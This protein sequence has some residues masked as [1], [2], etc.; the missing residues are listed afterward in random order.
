MGKAMLSWRE[1]VEYQLHVLDLAEKVVWQQ[2]YY[3]KI[4]RNVLQI[5]KSHGKSTKRGMLMYM[6]K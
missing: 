4:N 2:M 5:F 3:S 1:L 6:P